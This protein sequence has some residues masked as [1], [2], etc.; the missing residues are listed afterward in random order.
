ML[1]SAVVVLV[2]LA[3]I[4]VPV[5]RSLALRAPRRPR[6]RAVK[7][8]PA[9]KTRPLTLRKDQMDRDLLTLLSRET[10]RGKT[11]DD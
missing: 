6:E 2:L 5:V 8:Q 4:V 3:L 9:K 7:A 10:R 11:D 1:T